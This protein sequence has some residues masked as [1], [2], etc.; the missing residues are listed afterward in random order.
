MTLLVL[1][2]MMMLDQL[3][4]TETGHEEKHKSNA[5]GDSG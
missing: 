2:N 4:A 3:G 5:V 1:Q